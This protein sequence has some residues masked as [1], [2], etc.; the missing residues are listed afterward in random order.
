MINKQKKD[1]QVSIQKII[2]ASK[3]IFAD[4][5]FHRTTLS[6]IGKSCGL[7]RSTPSYY[8]KTKE[9]LYQ[10]VINQ[11]IEEEKQYVS[12]L[13][14]E[15]EV[16]IEALKDLLSRHMGYTF[17][18]PYLCKIIT[19]E[20]LDKDRHIWI[21]DYFPDMIDWSHSYLDQ[22][23][24]HGLIDKEINTYTLWLNAMAMTWLPIIT[25]HTF[26]KSIKHDIKDPSFVKFHQKQVEKLIFDSIIL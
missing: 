8:F 19:W 17:S 10:T 2:E 11:L 26:M 14:F 5:G 3:I 7:A 6:E 22:A 13:T 20:S 12:K 21:H 25:E 16:S 9:N 15:N 18:N 24:K 4:K 23:Q 1:A